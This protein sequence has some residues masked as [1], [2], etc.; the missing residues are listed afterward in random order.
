MSRLVWLAGLL[1]TIYLVGWASFLSF[2]SIAFMDYSTPDFE[3]S[4]VASVARDSVPLCCF[5][6]VGIASLRSWPHGRFRLWGL[7]AI[8]LQTS[9][10][11]W[12]L[13]NPEGIDVFTR[14][15]F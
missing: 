7:S 1:S 13:L 2:L 5:L 3:W 10:A 4:K 11:I 8:V 9:L 6:V 14:L 12:V 15:P